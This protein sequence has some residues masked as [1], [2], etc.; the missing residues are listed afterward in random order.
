MLIA[1]QVDIDPQYV[2]VYN[3]SYDTAV[4]CDEEHTNELYKNIAVQYYPV[5]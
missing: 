5:H 3:G 4:L 2:V 1:M